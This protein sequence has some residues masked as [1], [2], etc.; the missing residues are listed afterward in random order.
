MAF[1]CGVGIGSD[2]ELARRSC[3]EADAVALSQCVSLMLLLMD[4]R[5]GANAVYVHRNV[6]HT[7]LIRLFHGYKGLH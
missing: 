1:V 3:G 4:G 2:Q 7:K 5:Y 6:V